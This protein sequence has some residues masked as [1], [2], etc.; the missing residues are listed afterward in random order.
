MKK[1]L[2]SLLFTSLF[3]FKPLQSQESFFYEFEN[4]FNKKD[5][6]QSIE[7]RAIAFTASLAL[8]I[9]PVNIALEE[10]LN[11]W[12]PK[13][14]DVLKNFL[15]LNIKNYR[16]DITLKD[17]LQD[18]KI[19][20]GANAA[21]L[22]CLIINSSFTEKFI[23]SN[24][25]DL[26]SKNLIE[27]SHS[28]KPLSPFLDQIYERALKILKI[29]STFLL[30]IGSNDTVIGFSQD[31]VENAL[32]SI[33]VDVPVIEENE[34]LASLKTLDMPVLVINT[35]NILYKNTNKDSK[36]YLTIALS[37]AQNDM[38]IQMTNRCCMHGKFNNSAVKYS[39]LQL[40]FNYP[41]VYDFASNYYTNKFVNP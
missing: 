22:S 15:T 37:T 11:S 4:L 14:I 24:P 2:P 20:N 1:W 31:G 33:E 10:F 41:E 9:I 36:V 35:A 5:P 17:L 13:N 29:N 8:N 16:N 30:I 27:F 18:P 38:M 39:S 19:Y 12:N 25:I 6:W 21:L 34:F 32:D 26:I 40:A 3:V 23:E 28:I 7:F